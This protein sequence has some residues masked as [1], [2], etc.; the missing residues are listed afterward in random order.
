[1][2]KDHRDAPEPRSSGGINHPLLLGMIIGLLLGV[3]ISLAVALWLNRL[4]NPFMEKG[5]PLEPLPKIAP[6]QPSPPP[7]AARAAGEAAKGKAP[8]PPAADKSTK[9]AKTGEK[10]RFEFYN[11]LPGNEAAPAG[12]A[13]DKPADAKPAADKPAEKA[14]SNEQLYLQVGAFQKPAD[15]D[16]LKAKLALMGVEASVQQTTT[17]E[18]GVLHRVRTGPYGSPEDMNKVRNQ[19][20]QGGIQAT[21]VKV[22]NN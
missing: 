7:E 16:N 22:G 12:K 6:V 19:L 13:G 10:P 4:N 8:E 18:K 5:K 21:V 11:I 9:D 3:V 20:A 1:M 15:A 2:A 17:A 14:A